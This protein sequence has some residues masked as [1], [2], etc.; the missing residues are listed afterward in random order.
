MILEDFQKVNLNCKK[1][2][3]RLLSMTTYYIYKKTYYSGTWVSAWAYD[4][5]VLRLKEYGIF[6]P[7]V[8]ILGPGNTFSKRYKTL[9]TFYILY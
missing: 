6:P 2:D 3:Q 9:L 7:K 8:L 5:E 1:N 4:A